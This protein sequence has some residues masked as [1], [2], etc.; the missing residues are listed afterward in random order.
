MKRC[1]R[2]DHE[3]KQGERF[4]PTHRR[5]VLQELRDAGFL[6]RPA[7]LTQG[8]PKDAIEDTQETKWGNDD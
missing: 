6:T 3:T 1:E 5:I 7:R 8:R 2:C 4:C